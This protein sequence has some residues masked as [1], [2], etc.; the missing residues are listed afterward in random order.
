MVDYREILRL[1]SEPRN[2]QRQIA[3][4]VGSSHHTVKEVV[5][6]LISQGYVSGRPTLGIDGDG[7]SAF[8]QHY[9]HIPAGVYVTN[10]SRSS[11]AYQ[12]GVEE[13]DL[14]LSINDTRVTTQEELRTA[15]ADLNVGDSVEVVIFRN[16]TEYQVTL[17]LSEDKGGIS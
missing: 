12:K 8:Y 5:E 16:G 14:I 4:S 9:Y 11:D 1:A 10:V 3:A 7:L 15:V 6:Q 2:S 13:G 17:K